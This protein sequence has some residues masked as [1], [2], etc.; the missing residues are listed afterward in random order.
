MPLLWEMQT[1]QRPPACR[2]QSPKVPVSLLTPLAGTQP[3]MPHIVNVLSAPQSQETLPH[4]HEP[5]RP[6]PQAAR[7]ST[8]L[9]HTRL[10]L[11]SSMQPPAA[12]TSTPVL[13]GPRNILHLPSWLPGGGV[14]V[15]LW[16]PGKAVVQG[17]AGSRGPIRGRGQ[18]SKHA[19]SVPL[20]PSPPPD[21]S[22][23]QSLATLLNPPQLGGPGRG[24]RAGCGRQKE[25]VVRGRGGGDGD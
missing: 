22:S 5:S 16:H 24:Q 21:L 1:D 7:H 13:L 17:G 19:S 8:P 10:C 23:T 12:A 25:A 9:P 18:E 14:G 2:P 3:H 15:Q 6:S 4:R 11:A 20:K